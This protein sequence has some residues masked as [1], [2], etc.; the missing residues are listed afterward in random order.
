MHA[1]WPPLLDADRSI[2][3]AQMKKASEYWLFTPEI[4][5]RSRQE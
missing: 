4:T 5:G 3:L 2:Q 1:R